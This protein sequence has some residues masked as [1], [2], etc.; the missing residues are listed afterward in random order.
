MGV[1]FF[2]P[3]SLFGF[4]AMIV[5]PSAFVFALATAILQESRSWAAVSGVLGVILAVATVVLLHQASTLE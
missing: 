3:I 4:A 5:P 1:S 2:D